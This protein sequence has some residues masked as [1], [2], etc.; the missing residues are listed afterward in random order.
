MPD[1][2]FAIA[3]AAAVPYAAAPLL[4]FQLQIAN[5][6]PDEPI[7]AVTLQC[8]IRI[9]PLRRRYAVTE[10]EELRDLFGEPERWGKT[11]HSM[12]WTHAH[13]GVPAFTGSTTVDLPVPC[14][15]DFNVAAA[16]YFY[17]LEDGEVPLLL[18]FS[19]TIFY[20][21]A[22]G[23]LQIAQIPWEK[24]ATFRLPVTI[25]KQLMDL[26]YP[27]SAWL[28]LRADVFDRLYRYKIRGGLP[29]WEQ[30]LESLLPAEEGERHDAAR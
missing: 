28:C 17:A 3:G 4:A 11:M 14:T 19:G 1:L 20:E 23:A 13:L 16:K 24:E 29:T 12:L 2:S 27:N 18:L 21:T 9:E 5:A 26:Y 22:G 7:Q 30:T 10:H 25:W 8:Q 15:Y 6:P